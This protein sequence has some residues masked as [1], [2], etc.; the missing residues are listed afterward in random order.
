MKNKFIAIVKFRNFKKLTCI[1]L[2]DL[3]HYGTNAGTLSLTVF[4]AMSIKFMF[5]VF[6]II[7][8]TSPDSQTK[9][10]TVTKKD[11]EKEWWKRKPV[12]VSINEPWENEVDD[13]VAWTNSLDTD[14]LED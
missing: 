1:H 9:T 11:K 4:P 2:D 12:E 5:F 6:L 13:L 8:Q 3:R 14:A 7:V 10:D